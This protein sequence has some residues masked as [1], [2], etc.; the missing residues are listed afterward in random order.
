MADDT[1]YGT[2]LDLCSGLGEDNEE[3]P[4]GACGSPLEGVDEG[5]VA[6]QASGTAAHEEVG[7]SR[8][9]D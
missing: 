8:P 3:S 5:R 2:M 7:G 6:G 9:I 1:A 4:Q